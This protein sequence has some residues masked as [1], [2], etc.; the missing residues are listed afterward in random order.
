MVEP[1]RLQL[2][3]RKG[4]DLQALSIATNGLPAVNVARPSRWGNPFNFRS[5]AFCWI[6]LSFGC[7][8]DVAGR[9]EASVRAFREWIGD[10]PNKRTLSM[11]RQAVLGRGKKT[12][13]IG[14]KLEAGDAPS[15][16]QIIEA[17]HGKN[18]ACWCAPRQ[19]CH[20]DVLLELANRPICGAVKGRAV[21][22]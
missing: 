20:A 3:R 1:V 15:Q 19:P 13:A 16:A 18:I 10:D 6:A 14:A 2:S 4:F 9:Q 21:D 12:V 8:G 11:E 7:R 5:P 17:L 22:G